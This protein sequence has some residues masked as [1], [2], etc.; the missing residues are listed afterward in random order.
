MKRFVMA[1]I[2]SALFAAAL[3]AYNP[4]VNGESYL[5]LSS[6]WQLTGASSSSGGGLFNA[7]AESLSVNP[8]LTASEQRVNVILAYTAL[9]SGNKTNPVSY[10]NSFEAGILIPYKWAVFSGTVN[11]SMVPFLEMWTGNS[12]DIKAGLS[13]EI[14]DKLSV[15]LNLNTGFF[16]GANSDWSLSANLGF[17][18]K[19]G[20]L[21]FIK[22]FRYSAS[23]LN[24][25]KNYS[26]TSLPGCNPDAAV[27]QFPMIA[28]LKVGAAGTLFSNQVVKLGASADVTTPAFCNAIFDL[29]LQFSVKDMLYLSVAEKLNLGE[30]TA[31]YKN[32]IPS[33]GLFFKFTFGLK[34]DSATN[35]YIEKQG[36]SQSE[37]EAGAA[38]KQ[39]YGTVNA[40]SAGVNLNLGLKD[41]TPPVIN[42]WLDE[43]MEVET[44]PAS[45]GDAK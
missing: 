17:L 21:G 36:W 33:V 38:W 41:E 18:Y 11:G 4:P 14:T 10:G 37:L 34:L 25:G 13:K 9:I 16:W 20:H 35:E 30:L 42:L 12:I 15:G 5:E 43:D 44:I 28:T 22:D 2:V 31:G 8:A 26:K 40:I 32:L 39:L 19:Q 3:S 29:G 1:A 23:L 24:L 45:T 6:P 27:T 7:S